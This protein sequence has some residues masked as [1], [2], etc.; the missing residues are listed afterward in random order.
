MDVDGLLARLGLKL[1]LLRSGNLPVRSPIGGREVGSEAW[2]AYIRRTTATIN[3]SGSL[4]L[5]QGIVFA[6]D[7]DSE[8]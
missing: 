2:K 7:G 6:Q 8:R 3:I 4:L 5:A 1:G